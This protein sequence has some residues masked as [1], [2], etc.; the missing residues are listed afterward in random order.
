MNSWRLFSDE[1]DMPT[2]WPKRGEPTRTSTATSNTSPSGTLTSFAC[3]WGFCMCIPR[4]TPRDERDRLS[5][6]NSQVIPRARYR[7]R[8]QDSRKYPRASQKTSGSS[9]NTSGNAVGVA[10]I[11]A[12]PADP[13]RLAAGSLAHQ[14]QQILSVAGLAQRRRDPLL[15]PL[16]DPALPYRYLFGTGHLLALQGLQVA[17]PE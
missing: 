17:C 9:S 8:D 3:V 15:L 13:G 4:S 12:V 14:P 10:F 11:A 1:S 7:S 5:C 2:H 6:T 16:A